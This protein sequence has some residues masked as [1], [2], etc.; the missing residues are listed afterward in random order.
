MGV[1]TRIAGLD[2][3]PEPQ[4]YS[5]TE[6]ST[7]LAV[8]DSSGAVSSFDVTIPTGGTLTPW[9]TARGRAIELH[10]T[11]KGY[12]FG[13]IDNASFSDDNGLVTLSCI[14]H[15]GALNLYNI[16]A[17]PYSGTL[18]GAFAYYLSLAGITSGFTV[19]DSIQ[20]TPVHVVG[21]F[22][23]LWTNLK[24][25]AA[26]FR[27]EISLV[28][29]IIVL[30]PIRQREA[31]RG[32]DTQRGKALPGSPIAQFVTVYHYDTKPIVDEPIY[33]VGG[34]NEDVEVI[35]VNA[36]E[37]IEQVLELGASVYEVQQ[38]VFQE[39]IA[40]EFNQASVY[41]VVGNDGR[42]VTE[43]AWVGAGGSLNVFINEDTMSVTL[44]VTGPTGLPSNDGKELA[45]FAIAMAS[46]SGSSRYSSLRLVGSGVSF[47][48]TP[49]QFATGIPAERASKEEG[50]TIDNPFL[51]T[52]NDVYNAG[53]RA[54]REYAGR[55]F[56]LSGTV[57]A[58]N[59]IGDRGSIG[60]P[61][62]AEVKS[63]FAGKT[64]AQVKADAINAGKTYAD[65]R[66]YWR[67]LRRD[68]Y[69]NQAWG[70]IGGARVW[71]ATTRRYYRIRSGTS[72]RE[73]IQLQ[74]EDDLA[75]GDVKQAYAGLTYAQVKDRLAGATYG[76]V[77]VLGIVDG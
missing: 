19:E 11:R 63:Q 69:E 56:T 26:A 61:T 25:L 33:P 17:A 49:Y 20:D 70:N 65:G 54:A 71:D 43:A 12:I 74:A 34:W 44:R 8:S 22:G 66:N 53:A 60:L 72:M 48:K 10:D 35:S 21:W 55:K 13:T 28:S 52:L 51:T 38:P 23:E 47:T 7:P 62:Y 18:Q 77:A 68:Q 37:T 14:S 2:W 6:A 31:I 30:R 16:Q 39:T 59:Q 58:I 36:G 40:P 24:S 32:R 9:L 57:T 3:T 50:T 64:Y 67:D 15:L 27:A 76:D 75:Y 4:R 5:V 73:S 42:P 41:N 29:G 46:D 1:L 45:S